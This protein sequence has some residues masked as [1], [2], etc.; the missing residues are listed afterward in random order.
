MS[1]FV[2]NTFCSTQACNG[3]TNSKKQTNK[4]LIK[5]APKNKTCYN[6]KQTYTYMIMILLF[7]QIHKL[8]CCKITFE[9]S[10]SLSSAY[11]ATW[12]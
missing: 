10:E 5:Y 11:V 12:S 7:M 2:Y 4:Q 6:K 9:G 1:I 3:I 8:L